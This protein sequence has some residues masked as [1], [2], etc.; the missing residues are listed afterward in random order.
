MIVTRNIG[1]LA[2]RL[3]L[4]ALASQSGSVI[5]SGLTWKISRVNQSQ[6]LESHVSEEA[7]PVFN[8]TEGDYTLQVSYQNE[9]YDLGG[10]YLEK[11]TETDMV[12]ILAQGMTGT[13]DDYFSDFNAERDFHRRQ[14]ERNQQTDLYGA[15]TAPLREPNPDSL[16][17]EMGT[18]IM[19]H[20]KL[21]DSAQFDGVPPNFRPDPSENESAARL[22]YEKQLQLQLG[23]NAAPTPAPVR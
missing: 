9:I 1:I 4:T 20:P 11:N 18:S 17:G 22:T 3:K 5:Y 16:R 19:S 7:Q 14:Q 15:P 10:V 13:G 6:L 8:V 23:A 21:R 12:V 2:A